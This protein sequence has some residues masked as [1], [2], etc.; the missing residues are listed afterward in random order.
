[1]CEIGDAAHSGPGNPACDSGSATVGTGQM[2]DE[3]RGQGV[4]VYFID[5]DS[6]F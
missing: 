5:R 6:E 2:P 1:M 3:A 4:D